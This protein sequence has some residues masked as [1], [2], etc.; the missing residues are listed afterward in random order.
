MIQVAKIIRT[1]LTTTG[2]ISA[3]V[4]IV[5]VFGAIILGIARNPSLI[6]QL[7]SYVILEFTFFETTRLF[8]LIMTLLLIYVI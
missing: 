5:I 6:D 8:A 4:G 2:L 7:F 1:D 3:I